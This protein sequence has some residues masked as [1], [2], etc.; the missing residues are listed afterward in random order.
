[1]LAAP[2]P[3]S[4][5]LSF[6]AFKIPVR[7]HPSF[8]VTM[9]LLGGALSVGPNNRNLVPVFTFIVAGFISILVHEFGHGLTYRAFGQWPRLVLYYFGGLAIGQQ[10]ER[11]PWRRLMIILAGPAAGF[12]LMGLSLWA[13]GLFYGVG[14]GGLLAFLGL[15]IGLRLG[16]IEALQ[17]ALSRGE[18]PGFHFW[19]D[20][21]SVNLLW[22]VL[23]MLPVYPLDGGQA[24]GVLLG[25]RDRRRGQQWLHILSIAVAAL[26]IVYCLMSD[27]GL[28]ITAILFG[29]LALQNFQMLQALQHIRAG[30]FGDDADDWWRR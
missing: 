7:V 6:R 10:E 30:G 2:E 27:R 16:D 9:A 29:I 22:N 20:M 26:L 1:M 21:V 14:P 18:T 13:G 23:N 5:D 17:P 8:W 28:Q 24:A 12:A 11:N 4:F 3:T 19:W 15:P 25:L